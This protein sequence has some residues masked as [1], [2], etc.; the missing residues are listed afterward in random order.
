MRGRT[1]ALCVTGSIA[2]YKAVELARLLVSAGVHVVPVM[3]ASAKRFVGAL[4][5]AAICG[6]PVAS[7]MWDPSHPSE[8]HVVLA[9]RVD[10]VAI[11]PATADVLARLAHGRA[12]D[13]VTALALCA[14]CPVLAAPAMHPAMWDHPATRRNAAELAAQKRVQ[15]IGPVHGEVASGDSGVGRMV[16]P[17]EI[18]DALSALL[19]PR[20]LS[21]LRVIVTAG[22]TFEDLDPV[23]FIGNRSSGRMGF[24]LAERAAR[25][26]A[27]VTLIAGPVGQTTPPGVRRIDVRAAADMR[28]ALWEALGPDLSGAD[29]LVMAAAVADY[30]PLHPSRSK[31]KK[32]A[33]RISLELARN[34]DLL[35][36]IG[37]ARLGRR[38]V[39]VGFALETG[40]GEELVRHARGKLVEKRLDLVVA[41]EAGDSLGRQE[42]RATFV[43]AGGVEPLPV[44]S[45]ADIADAILERVRGAWRGGLRGISASD[46]ARDVQDDG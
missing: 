44:M 37:A 6:E 32:S 18:A 34:P 3:T 19:S 26:G 11:V 24:A 43:S 42:A 33:D 15:L 25:R 7:D 29:A 5:F 2:A 22:P 9:R 17:K 13:L 41:N 28:A 1:I 14:Q 27:D 16:E 8:A 40:E 23:R 38:P 21:G 10:A 36:E 46:P 30:R 12:D 45:K 4:T 39:L 20:D 35:G 31:L